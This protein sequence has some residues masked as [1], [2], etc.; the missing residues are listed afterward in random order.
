MSDSPGNPKNVAYLKDA[1]RKS[2]GEMDKL[3]DLLLG[4][5]Y[6]EL[7]ALKAQ[8]ENKTSYANSVADI[9]AEAIDIRSA[10]DQSL[11]KSL[12]PSVEDAIQVS[13]RKDPQP[14]VDALFPIIGPMIRKSISEAIKSMMQSLDNTLSNSMSVR[15]IKWRLDA[16]RTGRPYS[17]IVLLNTLIYQV[18]QVFLIHRETGLLLQH[19]ESEKAIIKDPDMVSGM[20]TAIQDFV[21]DSFEVSKSEQLD[22]MRLG[23]LT[24][25]LVHGSGASIAAVVHGNPPSDLRTSLLEASEEIHAQHSERFAEFS[26]DTDQFNDA[27]PLLES[28]L[29]SQTQQRT[30]RKPWPAIILLV[31]VALATITYSLFEYLEYKD[32]K[33]AVTRLNNEPGIVVIDAGKSEGDYFVRGLR[34]V[35]A[36]QPGEVIGQ[37]FTD[38]YP[39]NML[40]T[41]YISVEDTM[42]LQ[43]V[44][45]QLSVP[46]S[47]EMKLIDGVLTLSGNASDA[48]ISK[49]TTQFHNLPGVNLIVTDGLLDLNR[50]QRMFDTIS[51]GIER[52]AVF[53]R[54]GASELTRVQISDIDTLAAKIKQM[55]AA[56]RVIKHNYR[57]R[58]LGHSDSSGTEELNM[59]VSKARAQGM[60]QMLV[61][62]GVR[63]DILIAEGVSDRF[64]VSRTVGNTGAYQSDR[65]VTMN[66]IIKQ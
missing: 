42:V 50:Y 49:V 62:R 44:R 57:I 1:V 26:G 3:R 18:E 61:D 52:F 29:L 11:S 33:T 30:K 32:W 41:P 60:L 39:V 56:S 20:L 5:D 4:S 59:V 23:E 16:R 21:K 10:R 28:C 17:E 35:Y 2:H 9:V 55:D 25:S 7:L 27:Q 40:F 46:E 24:V 48:W 22:S 31:L 8:L 45:Q 63:P 43:R 51:A 38:K 36:E 13:V 53:Y 15:S 6:Q 37:E 34:D 47:V 19:V 66:V 12:A 14:I 54:A 58:I 65:R 64:P